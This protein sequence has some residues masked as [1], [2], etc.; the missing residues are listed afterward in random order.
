MKPTIARLHQLLEYNPVTG[1]FRWRSPN[2]HQ[3]KNWFRGNK[4]VRQYRR[5]WFDNH[6]YMAHVIAWALMTGDWPNKELDH[7]DHDQNNNCWNNLRL[8]T[9]SQNGKNRRRNSNNKTGVRGVT[10]Y[11]NRFRVQIGF[12]REHIHIGIFDTIEAATQARKLAEKHY[13]GEF[14][15]P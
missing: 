8:A 10:V 15:Q 9:H 12:H 1:L 5:L 13:Y 7:R 3:A 11:G 14:A 2:A 6:H 4:S